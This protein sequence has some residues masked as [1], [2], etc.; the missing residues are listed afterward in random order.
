APRDAV[1]LVR[2]RGFSRIPIYRQRETNIVGVVSVKDLLNRGASVPTLDV[3]KRTPYYVPE[4]KR[5]D[6]LLREMQRNR[7]HMAV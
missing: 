3:L 5:I 1:A 7:T 4:T 2:E 6:D